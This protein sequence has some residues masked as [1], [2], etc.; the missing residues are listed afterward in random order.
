MITSFL[1]EHQYQAASYSDPGYCRA[2]SHIVAKI[3]GNN[4]KHFLDLLLVKGL[5]YCDIYSMRA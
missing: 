5:D 2:L 3:I 4:L 1:P